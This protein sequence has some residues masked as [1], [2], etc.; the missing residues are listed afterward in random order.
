VICFDVS[1]NEEKLCRAGIDG[2]GTLSTITTFDS[3]TYDDG[4]RKELSIDIGAGVNDPNDEE[5]G[6][7]L[8]WVFRKGLKAGDRITI[9]I[10]EAESCDEPSS[11]KPIRDEQ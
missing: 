10:V 2:D 4:K 9:D 3:H 8:R 6:E 1:L 7:F 11:R 5:R